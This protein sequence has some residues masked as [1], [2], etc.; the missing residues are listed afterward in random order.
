[1]SNEPWAD[2]NQP[3]DDGQKPNPLRE[4]ARQLEKQ[5]KELEKKLKEL[6]A[7]LRKNTVETVLKAKGYSP[8]TAALIPESVEP[9][10]DAIAK[11]LEEYADIL[12]PLETNES[13]TGESGAGEEVEQDAQTMS[14][15][16]R[17]TNVAQPSGAIADL[18][19]R[20]MS[21][22]LTREE[23]LAMVHKA[24]GGIGSG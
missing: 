21:P 5:N 7:Q 17:A 23:L 24:G 19:A 3:N 4:H 10:E 1:M 13:S 6:Q 11:W 20:L 2:N 12:R 15:I 18:Q 16:S 22:D 9:T 14:R 8:K